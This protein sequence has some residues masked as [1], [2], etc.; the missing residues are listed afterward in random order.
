M[1]HVLASPVAA[2]RRGLLLWVGVTAGAVLGGML[3][4]PAAVA[5]VRPSGAAVT[6]T[7]LLVGCCAVVALV[8]LGG[9]WLAA[10]DVAW[11]VLRPARLR[12]RLRARRVGPVRAGLLAL[13]GVTA[14]A[15]PVSAGTPE[16]AP[17]PA[18][19]DVDADALAGLPLPERP[20]DGPAP[21]RSRTVQVRPGDTLWAIAVRA[22]GPEASAADVTAYWRRIHARNAPVIGPDPDRI[23]PGQVVHLP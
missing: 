22:L 12:T 17:P 20:V 18:A 11:T 14:F 21:A 6:F 15:A 1:E 19:L 5:L 10:S 7:D 16:P 3:A 9:L 2:C 13:C 23:L 4:G 8:A